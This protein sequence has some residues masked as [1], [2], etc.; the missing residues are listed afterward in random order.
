MWDW[1]PFPRIYVFTSKKKARR[2]IRRKFDHDFNWIGKSAQTDYFK[3]GGEESQAVITIPKREMSMSHKIALIAHECSHIVD[4]WLE[5]IGEEDAGGE[6]RAYATQCAV[7]TVCDKLG[8]EW[9]T[10]TQQT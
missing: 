4:A 7:L 1:F 6:V 10:E 2:F 5:D 3:M 8:E 9:F